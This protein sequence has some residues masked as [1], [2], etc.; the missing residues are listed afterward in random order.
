[1]QNK[2]SVAQQDLN[3]LPA[4]SRRELLL[5]LGA[6]ATFAV[7]TPTLAA[8]PGHDHSKHSTQQPDMLD[9]A[10]ACVD[11]GERCIAHCLVSFQEGDLQLADCA[12]KVHEMRAICDA[13][14]YLLAANSSYVRD[15]APVCARVCEDCEKECRK[16]EEHIECKACAEACADL[17]DQIKLVFD[18]A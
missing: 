2:D 12:A 9:A 8:M 18:K 7:A 11:K 17:V 14:S 16:H 13:F 15:Y 5:G 6:A 4:I 3:S 1:M 10:N